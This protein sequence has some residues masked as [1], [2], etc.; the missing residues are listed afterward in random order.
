MPAAAANASRR[1]PRDGARV[2]PDGPHV[3]GVPQPA[4]RRHPAGR[5]RATTGPVADVLEVRPPLG[6]ARSSTPPDAAA[7]AAA[8]ILVAIPPAPTQ[9]GAGHGDGVEVGGR[10][11]VRAAARSV[12][13]SP[14]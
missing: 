12:R 13:G 11:H 10:V 4:T 9:V 6:P 5:N 14:S 7:I 2:D 3:G 1:A 8:V